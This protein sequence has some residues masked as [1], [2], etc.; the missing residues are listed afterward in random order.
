MWISDRLLVVVSAG[1][2]FELGEHALKT[3]LEAPLFS[4]SELCGDDKAGEAHDGLVD[5][6]EA[7]LERCGGGRAHRIGRGLSPHH[8]Q[9][10]SEELTPVRLVGHPVG[11]EQSE[12]LAGLEAVTLHGAKDGFL[13]LCGQGAQ[14]VGQ[15]GSKGAPGKLFLGHGR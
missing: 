10:R 3:G 13:I 6:L 7:P 5:V 9:G 2:C 15:S 12:S 1:G 11:C 8:T 14:R 4:R